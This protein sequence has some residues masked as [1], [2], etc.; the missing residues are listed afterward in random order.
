MSNKPELLDNF[1]VRIQFENSVQLD[2][3]RSVK[4]E[5]MGYLIRTLKNSKIDIKI[6]LK[7]E[8]HQDKL[9]TEDQKLQ[10]MLKKNPSLVKM[11]NLF[12]LDFNG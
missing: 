5:L 11:K 7:H 12:N 6:E 3:M 2:Q 8:S 4:P 10:A 9:L 1:K